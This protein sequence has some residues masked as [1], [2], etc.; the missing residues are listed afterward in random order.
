MEA[1]KATLNQLSAKNGLIIGTIIIVISL[2]IHFINP[3]L[4]YTNIWI[5]LGTFAICIGLLVYSGRSIRNE[6]G[7]YWSFGD[8]FKSFLII[9]LILTAFTTLYNILLMTV[10][11]P[12]LPAKA[13][14]AI[15]E[16]QRTMMAKMGVSE[17]Q[18]DEALAKGGNME[19]K[20]K[21]TGKNIVTSFGV[22]L[23]IYGVIALILA[24]CLKKNAPLFKS[25]VEE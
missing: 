12:G 9:A 4:P 25:S 10:I 17:D 21:I 18:I 20:L 7:G 5:Q 2:V 22:A 14:A 13:A 11:D 23:A 3:L 24:A 19:E 8:A 15:E 6:L 1:Q 16:S